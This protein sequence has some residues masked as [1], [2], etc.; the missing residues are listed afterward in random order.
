MYKYQHDMRYE[1]NAAAVAHE[2]LHLFGAWDLY[3]LNNRDH[4]RAIKTSLMF[5]QAVMLNTFR[6]IWE[7]QIDEITA[8]LVGLKEQGKDW[9]RW[10]EPDQLTYESE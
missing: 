7:C 6:E 4:A 8:W 1:T 5:P 2:I 9:Y 10:F 3:E